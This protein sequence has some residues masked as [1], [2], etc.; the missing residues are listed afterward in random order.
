MV[1]ALAPKA[2]LAPAISIVL[3]TLMFLGCQNEPS[4]VEPIGMLDQGEI[5]KIT[6][7]AGATIDSAT[8]YINVTTALS[9][10]VTL[11]RIN[12]DWGELTVTWNNFGAV[13]ASTSR[14]SSADAMDAAMSSMER[15]RNAAL[16]AMGFVLFVVSVASILR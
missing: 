1:G 9:E 10:E 4:F 14:P 7:P 12:S 16:V 13:T 11:H 2:K 3:T 6:I 15:R 8:F 5:S